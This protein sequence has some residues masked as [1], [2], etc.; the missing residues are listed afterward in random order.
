MQKSS[1]NISKSKPKKNKNNNIIIS[2]DAEKAFDKI[3]HKVIIKT[4]SKLGIK[5][6]FLS[7][8]NT[9]PKPFS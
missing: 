5:G 4:L 2:I 7:L 1:Q 3:Q 8:I 9:I 6:N